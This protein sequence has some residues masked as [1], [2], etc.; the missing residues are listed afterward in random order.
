MISWINI[1]CT[2]I[3]FL[4]NYLKPKKD[5]YF[6]DMTM[7]PPKK[8]T[9]PKVEIKKPDGPLPFQVCLITVTPRGPNW[10]TTGHVF[11]LLKTRLYVIIL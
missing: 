8:I 7:P 2:I 11:R 5:P 9:L 10:A 4:E 6:I 3:I 1:L